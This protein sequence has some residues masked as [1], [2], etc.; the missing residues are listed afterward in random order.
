[1]SNVAD[2]SRQPKTVATVHKCDA[3]KMHLWA[4]LKDLSDVAAAPTYETAAEIVKN[5]LRY[6][7]AAETVLNRIISSRNELIIEEN[8]DESAFRLRIGGD[9]KLARNCWLVA[10]HVEYKTLLQQGTPLSVE[11]EDTSLIEMQQLV[12]ESSSA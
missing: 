3:L 7:R 11:A 1:M 9:E 2:T 6:E 10:K 8:L 5:D 4:D 12:N